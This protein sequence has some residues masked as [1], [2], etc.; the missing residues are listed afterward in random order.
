MSKLELINAS[1]A[2]QEA[3][4][5]VNAANNGL[6]AGGGICGVIFGKAGM[7]E[8]TD[9]CSKYKTPLHDGDAVITPAFNMKNA[10]AI[11]HAVGP[12]FAVTPKAFKELFD[13]YY[14]SLTVLKEN[15]YHSISFPLISS[16]IFGGA[17]A[18]P[19]GESAKQ[20]L[21]AYKKFVDDHPDYD[22]SVKLCAFTAAEMLSAGKEVTELKAMTLREKILQMC[23]ITPREL[24]DWDMI[25]AGGEVRDMLTKYPVGGVIF[26]EDQLKEPEQTRKLLSQLQAYAREA[27]IPRLFLCIDEEGGKVVRIANKPVFGVKNPGPMRNIGTREEAFETGRYIGKYLSALGFNVDFAPDADV[28]T[29]PGSRIIGDRS[30]GN[31]PQKVTE[32]AA[33]VSDGLHEY[34]IL[35]CFKHF[36][37]HGAVEADTH[38]GHA[39]TDKSLEDLISCEIIP[40]AKAGELGADMVMAAHISVPAILGDNTPC[41]LSEYM[42]TKVLKEQLG[43]DG[44]VITDALNMGAVTKELAA[45]EAAVMAVKA[46]VDILLMPPD[47]DAAVGAIEAAVKKGEIAEE[48]IDESVGKILAKKRKM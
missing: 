5:V 12:N 14:N 35:S 26:F 30:F 15:G 19:A 28:L 31:D 44:L 16:G 21:R 10:K 17:L 37:G 22:I 25:A 3:D 2:D 41:S 48:R 1:C 24:G 11:I 38:E 27:G 33:A 46:G 8:L 29:A 18:D 4:V 7:R 13:A 32:F 42:L 39:Y 36:P 34:G 43:Y 40:F 20:C 47:L 9:A 45:G 6:W 23:V